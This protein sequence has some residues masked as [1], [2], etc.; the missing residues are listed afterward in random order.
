MTPGDDQQQV[1]TLTP[2]DSRML[3]TMTGTIEIK[4]PRDTVADAGLLAP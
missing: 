4:A 3:P 2:I 1:P